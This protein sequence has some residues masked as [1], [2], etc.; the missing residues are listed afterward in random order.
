M[1]L[2]IDGDDR[3]AVRYGQASSRGSTGSLN[4][5]WKER[6]VDAVD[7]AGEVGRARHSSSRTL[8]TKKGLV[9]GNEFERFEPSW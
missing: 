9:P 4:S 1:I 3:G 8:P 5:L 7:N 2:E 6:S